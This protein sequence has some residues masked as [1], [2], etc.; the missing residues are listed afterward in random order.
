MKCK[1]KELKTRLYTIYDKT[2]QQSLQIFEARNDQHAQRSFQTALANEPYGED[3]ELLYIGE[4]DHDAAEIDPQI[5]PENIPVSLP[6]K[7]NDK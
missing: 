5:P 3:F 2:A 4:Y 7:E 1:E 6:R